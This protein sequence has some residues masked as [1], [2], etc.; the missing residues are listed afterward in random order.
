MR[1]MNQVE[2]A[3]LLLMVAMGFAVGLLVGYCGYLR[4]GLIAILIMVMV[5][6]WLAPGEA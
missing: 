1:Q 2:S 6:T 5:A 3:A 4:G